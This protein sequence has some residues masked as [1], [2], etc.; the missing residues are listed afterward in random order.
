MAEA[1]AGDPRARGMR[2]EFAYGGMPD[3]DERFNT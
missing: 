2:G 3:L 1:V